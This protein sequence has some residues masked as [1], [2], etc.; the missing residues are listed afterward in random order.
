MIPIAKNILVVD[1]EGNEYEATWPKRARG[2]VKNGR[3]R[4]LSKNKICLACP[5]WIDME[6]NEMTD[7]IMT[8]IQIE[9][10]AVEAFRTAVAAENEDNR[11][12][13]A[14]MAEDQRSS[15]EDTVG[16]EGNTSSR[17]TEPHLI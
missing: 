7:I 15:T 10:D 4:F 5:P 17:A 16:A 9:K 13:E 2:L 11:A 12:S 8:D 3:A 14:S 6:D 1:E